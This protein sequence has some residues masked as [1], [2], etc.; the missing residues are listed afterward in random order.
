M[1]ARA[2]KPHL[3]QRSAHK[4]LLLNAEGEGRGWGGKTADLFRLQAQ[5]SMEDN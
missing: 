1:L 2:R 4:Q 3:V 5:V